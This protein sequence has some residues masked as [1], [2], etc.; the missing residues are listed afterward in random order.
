[1]RLLPGLLLSITLMVA[2][3]TEPPT[4]HPTPVRVIVAHTEQGTSGYPYSAVVHPYDQVNVEFR[5]EGYIEEIPTREVLGQVRRLQAGDYITKGEVLAKVNDEQYLDKVVEAAADVSKAEAVRR[6]ADLD[7]KRASALFATA[8]ITAPDY[9]TAREEYEVAQASVVGSKASL[10]RARE[11][12]ND[13]VLR[14]PLTGIILQ[15]KITIGSLV[16]TE[17]IGFVVADTSRV[18]VVFTVPDV[19]LVY[20][21]LGKVIT[22]RTESQPDKVFTGKITEVAPMAESRT[23]VFAITV[24]VPNPNALLKPGMVMSLILDKIRP[25]PNRVVIPLSC[26]VKHPSGREGFAVFVLELDQEVLRARLRRVVP[27]P[28]LGNSIVILQGL[29]MGERVVSNGA[30]LL[31]DGQAVRVMP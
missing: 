23:R 19:V 9:D 7:Y 17:N 1:M 21:E 3:H 30:A 25:P 14:S 6:K 18:K 16:R 4:K 29:T 5:T 15:R 10:D 27:G 2:C 12:L 24:T 11:N 8:S 26:L 28:V 20:T 31:Q 13:T 22:M